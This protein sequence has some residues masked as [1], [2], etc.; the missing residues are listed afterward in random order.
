MATTVSMPQ[1]GESVVEGTIAKWLV[2]EGDAVQEDQPLVEITTDK[3]DTEIPSPAAGVIGRIRVPAGETVKVGTVLCEIEGEGK[4]ARAAGT[5]AAQRAARAAA[6]APV[7]PAVATPV[8]AQTPRSAAA[9]VPEAAP[10]GAAR[11]ATAAPG[12]AG[13]PRAAAGAALRPAPPRE[14]RSGSAAGAVVAGSTRA[15]RAE[16]GV[17]LDETRAEAAG[18]KRR[19]ARPAGGGD[20]DGDAS[21]GE[22]RVTPVVRK[23]AAEHGVD[24]SRISGSGVGGRI[25]KEDLLRHLN[26]T[27][28]ADTALAERAEYGNVLG[29]ESPRPEAA[30]PRAG[31]AP[32]A[33]DAAA[34]GLAE[35]QAA[36]PPAA[37]AAPVRPGLELRDYAPA[38]VQ[39][40]EGERVE[41]FSRRRKIIAEHMVYSKA[42]SPHV[43]TMAE[44]D[45]AAVAA[46]RESTKR[47]FRESEGLSL[48]YLHFVI[49]ATARALRDYPRVNAVVGKDELILRRDVNIGVAVETEQ[50]LVVPVVR[51]ADR[52]SLRGVA[53]AVEELAVKARE[54]KLRLEDLQGGTFTIS[55]PGREGNLVGFAVINQPQLGI[56]RMGEIKKRPVVVEVDGADAIAI[57][58]IML[59]SLSY[60]HRVIDGVTGNSFL[61]RVKEYLERGEF[62]V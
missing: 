27:S 43:Y 35:G 4:P 59:L 44:V 38:P 24:L 16:P 32:A 11:A 6:V 2:A 15:A 46:L 30:G 50:G 14:A 31:V 53:R 48:T 28:M 17:A 9:G 22:R 18:E 41:P 19:K 5:G 23:M 13:A 57:R 29:V 56:L 54:R 7:E 36:G 10:P 20:G 51:N 61:Y 34:A 21:A 1:L 33:E 25:T 26:L 8:S 40:G 52:L 45:M 62:E 49:V 3:I 47:A 37:G 60:D 12:S 58:P 55:N 39:A 42:V